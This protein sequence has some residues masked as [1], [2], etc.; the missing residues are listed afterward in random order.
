MADQGRHASQG[1]RRPND[2]LKAADFVFVHEFIIPT[3]DCSIREELN[4]GVLV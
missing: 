1:R 3:N 4:F 2:V